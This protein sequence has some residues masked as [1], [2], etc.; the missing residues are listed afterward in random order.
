[1]GGNMP[2]IEAPGRATDQGSEQASD[3]IPEQGFLEVS[4]PAPES[5]VDFATDPA[6]EITDP[7]WAPTAA[8]ATPSVR[9]RKRISAGTIIWPSF[10]IAAVL[11]TL[12]LF[13]M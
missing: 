11:V 8:D 9:P 10:V 3:Q 2:E 13:W 1:D 12:V 4:S 5:G 6:P 7:H